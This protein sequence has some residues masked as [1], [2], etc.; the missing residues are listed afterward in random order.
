MWVMYRGK[1][2]F[3]SL[4]AFRHSGIHKGIKIRSRTPGLDICF[5]GCIFF[6]R[7]LRFNFTKDALAYHRFGAVL[8]S[9]GIDK[10]IPDR[11]WISM[12]TGTGK[13]RH[14]ERNKKEEQVFHFIWISPKVAAVFT[15]PFTLMDESWVKGQSEIH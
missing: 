1:Q 14:H 3:R 12:V 6:V 11:L 5:Q 8:F 2:P 4:F 9:A 7:V 13:Q 15:L 10:I